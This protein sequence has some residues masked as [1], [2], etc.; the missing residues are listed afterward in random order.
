[1]ITDKIVIVRGGGD[2]AT[3]CIQKLYRSGFKVLVLESGNPLCIRRTV[4]AV[5]YTHLDVYKRTEWQ[6]NSES[7]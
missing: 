3:G 7:E 4:S 5:S 2:V 1:M 6:K